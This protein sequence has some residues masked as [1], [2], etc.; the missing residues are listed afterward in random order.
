MQLA[1]M[2]R[3]I[4]R[5]SHKTGLPPGSLVF[6]G[7][8]QAE[9]IQITVID[10]SVDHLEEKV[11]TTAREAFTFRDTATVSWIDI[12]SVH[13]VE[14]I[15]QIGEHFAIHPLVQED[16]V[17]TSQ[18]PKVE[19]Y[20]GALYIVIKMLYYDEHHRRLEAEQVSLIMGHT[21]VLSFQEQA[22]D[23]FGPVR[24][25]LR[26]GRGRL[27]QCGTDYLAYAL[28]D[29]IVD[30][31]FLVLETMSE[32][33]EEL[34]VEVAGNPG[35]ETQRAI[36]NLHR[37]LV[38]LRKAVWP[39]RELI[40]SLERSESALITA[41]IKPFLRDTYDHAVQVLDVTESLR[42]MVAVLRDA[43]YAALSHRM[44]E[45]MKVL[46]IIATIFIPLTFIAGVYGM[47]FDYMPELHMRYGYPVSLLMML[48]IGMLLVGYFKWKKWF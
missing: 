23:V 43:Y 21:Y 45:I 48:G 29:V 24:E 31:Y 26:S 15:Q 47:N 41:D 34:E 39:V 32:D 14:A 37:Q 5:R 12:D 42:E 16:I 6:T 19:E 20:E 18:R 36:G 22:G 8:K 9:Q 4:H 40:S 11:L 7:E 28:L 10:Y 33:I 25:R 35:Q 27:R 44:N 13:D 38:V 17:N 30:N 3:F 2:A 1:V 46:T